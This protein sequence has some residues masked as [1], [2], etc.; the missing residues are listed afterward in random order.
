MPKNILILLLF[1][2]VI[3]LSVY[4]VW[5]ISQPR[6]L[7]LDEMKANGFIMYGENQRVREYEL[8]DHNGQPFT[9]DDFQKKKLNFVYFGYTSCPTE[10]PVMMSVMRQLYEKIETDQIAYYLVSFDPEIDTLDRLKTYVTGFNDEFMGLTGEITEVTKFGY[11]L[12][13]EKLAPMENHLNQRVIEHTNHLILINSEAE[14]I[15]IFKAP[16]ESS[17]MALVIKSLLRKY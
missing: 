8:I 5:R 2:I 16:F 4:S 10:C 11:Q 13:V 6:I 17:S 1:A 7:S 15:G 12:G 14:V 3:F 9:N